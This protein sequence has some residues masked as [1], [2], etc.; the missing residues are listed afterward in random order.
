[1]NAIIILLA[2]AFFAGQAQ[3]TPL[4]ISGDV[5][6]S[7]THSAVA[8]ARVSLAG[9]LAVR[10]VDTDVKGNFVL[11]LSGSVHAGQ[12]VTLLVKKNDYNSYEEHIVVALGGA[13]PQHISL[14]PAIPKPRP[15]PS[16]RS[17]YVRGN[18]SDGNGGAVVGAEVLIRGG[19]RSQ[20][21]DK[22]GEFR[23]ENITPPPDVGY[24]VTFEVVGWIVD[25]PRMGEFGRT[26][27][28]SPSA[29]PIRLRVLKAGDQAFLRGSSIERTV[30]QRVFFFGDSD[31]KLDNVAFRPSLA[32]VAL[33]GQAEFRVVS[34]SSGTSSSPSMRPGSGARVWAE[35]EQQ[36]QSDWQRFLSQRAAEIRI[37]LKELSSAVYEWAEHPQNEYQKGLAALYRGNYKNAAL[38]FREALDSENAS[39]EQLYMS[40]A[41]AEFKG[42]NF[43]ESSV[44][45]EKLATL[46]PQDALVQRNL[47]IVGRKGELS[48]QSK[49]VDQK[50][51][52]I[53]RDAMGYVAHHESLMLRSLFDTPMAGSAS[54]HGI[55][56][57]FDEVTKNVGGFELI[58]EQ[59]VKSQP[60]Q[61]TQYVTRSRFEK[62]EIEMVVSFDDNNL[63]DT[64]I[65]RDLLNKSEWEFPR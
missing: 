16:R 17:L 30:G 35:E 50:R 33:D 25:D 11:V 22:A 6:D 34:M 55:G 44:F 13:P 21:T 57:L 24:P 40:V 47:A 62:G 48:G 27:L 51:L 52:G 29:E 38:D 14:E 39:K 19:P 3:N 28:P 41:Y 54:E 64:I 56:R 59:S 8:G 15:S 20:P 26:Y 45:L 63:I 43:A 58:L 61:P 37:P 46:H 32:T 23:I 53:C 65:F 4:A 60:S 31:A 9:N 49:A 10:D 2:T 1:M 42:G 12:T 36:D 7:K 5:T 18:V